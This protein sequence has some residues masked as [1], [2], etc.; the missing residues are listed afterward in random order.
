MK[1][2]ALLAQADTIEAAVEVARRHAEKLEQSILARAS[3]GELVPQDPND[4]PA[5]V[6]LDHTRA[7]REKSSAARRTVSGKRQK[8]REST[9]GITNV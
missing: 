3:R 4:E 6:L 1:N 9:N 8:E 7:E 2:Q 5:S